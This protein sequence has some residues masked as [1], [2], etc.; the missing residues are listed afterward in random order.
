[1]FSRRDSRV[2]NLSSLK[3][4]VM[5]KLTVKED[6]PIDYEALAEPIDPDAPTLTEM[7]EPWEVTDYSPQISSKAIVDVTHDLTAIKI[8]TALRLIENCQLELSME[9]AQVPEVG[10]IIDL[11]AM[12][13]KPPVATNSVAAERE[14]YIY[15][16]MHPDLSHPKLATWY[17]IL[18]DEE[19]MAYYAVD[20]EALRAI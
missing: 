19:A 5:D 6:A 7:L 14:V 1:M 2:A 10:N 16:A 12:A 20:V 18:E 9:A 17:R 4:A 3:A 13:E 15:L 11:E 8:E